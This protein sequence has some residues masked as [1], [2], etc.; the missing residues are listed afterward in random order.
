[1]MDDIFRLHHGISVAMKV[2]HSSSCHFNISNW[3]GL[4]PHVALFIGKY[5]YTYWYNNNN[6]SKN[7]Y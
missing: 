5:V 4:Y 7:E 6:T 3:P 2:A 1:M